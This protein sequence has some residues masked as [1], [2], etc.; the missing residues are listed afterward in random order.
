MSLIK[1]L[2]PP[3]QDF[4]RNLTHGASPR[5]S[6]V[7]S[8][9]IQNGEVAATFSDPAIWIQ[10]RNCASWDATFSAGRWL[11]RQEQLSPLLLKPPSAAS[12]WK[13]V[14]RGPGRGAPRPAKGLVQKEM[15]RWPTLRLGVVGERAA[16]TP[17]PASQASHNCW[18]CRMSCLQGV[19][20]WSPNRIPWPSL[21]CFSQTQL[22]RPL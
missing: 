10:R 18:V 5:P 4:V 7:P 1:W 16:H 22:L 20:F 12:N 19:R 17:A 14:G 11:S 9:L 2:V 3:D 15:K 13:P 6:D 8:T 21:A